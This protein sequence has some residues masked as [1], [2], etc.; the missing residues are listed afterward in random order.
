M[1]EQLYRT[2]YADASG[3]VDSERLR[4][5]WKGECLNRHT[6]R[7]LRSRWSCLGTARVSIKV[8]GGITR[9][10]EEVLG[11]KCAKLPCSYEKSLGIATCF[12]RFHATHAISRLDILAFLM[13]FCRWVD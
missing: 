10:G 12:T 13:L 1:L 5:H 2:H 8:G 11:L 3:E 9:R 4:E 7:S 6:D